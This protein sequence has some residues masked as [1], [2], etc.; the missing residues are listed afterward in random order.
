MPDRITVP[1]VMLP[2]NMDILLE[3]PI[4]C[5]AVSLVRYSQ[6][7]MISEGVVL[8]LHNADKERAAELG[9]Q[10]GGTS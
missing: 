4:P 1:L 3:H 8:V 6:D 7:D 2:G 9:F 5:T 10:F